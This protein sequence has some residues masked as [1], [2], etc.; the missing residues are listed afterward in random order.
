[1]TGEQVLSNIVT[2]FFSPLYQIVVAI[3]VVYFMYGVARYMYDLN[4]S[5]AQE[6]N[7]GRSHL[8]WGMVGL[9]IVLSVGGILKLFDQ[10]FG[11]FFK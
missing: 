7:F 9:F 4:A 11:G 6:Q 5:N 10:V 1:M 8:L 2:E 3:A